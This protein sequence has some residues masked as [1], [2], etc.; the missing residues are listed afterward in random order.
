MEKPRVTPIVH[1]PAKAVTRKRVF[2]DKAKQRRS[3]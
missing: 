3:D 2:N 1:H